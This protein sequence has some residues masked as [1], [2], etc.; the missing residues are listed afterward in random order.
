MPKCDVCGKNIKNPDSKAHINSKFHQAA[1]KKQKAS[2]PKKKPASKKKT[3][4]YMG[5]KSALAWAPIRRLMK[6]QGATIV[7]RDA[8]DLLIE[9]LA[10]TVMSITESAQGFTNH[11]KRKKI[12]RGDIYLALKYM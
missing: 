5:S 7:A 12:T 3:K 10:S 8:V 1:L 2:K 9:H 11:A 4:R 6:R